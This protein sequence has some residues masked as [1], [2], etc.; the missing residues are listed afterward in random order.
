MKN[1]IKVAFLSSIIA[2]AMVYVILEWRPL[3]SDM[4]RPP[5]VSW[6]SSPVGLTVP[7]AP[8]KLTEDERNNIDIYQKYSPGVVNIT[9][10]TV[11]YN[12]FLQPFPQQGMGSG[13]VI[14]NQGHIVTNF[15]VVRDAD[16]LQV[17]LADKSKHNA[18]VVG[19]DPN[20]DLAVIQ[21][22][23]PRGGLTPIP[24]G[25]SKGLLV[26]QKVLAI[27]NPFGLDRTMTTGI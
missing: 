20:N 26:G 13:A 9:T 15:H 17:T 8:D 24:L 10:I 18:R 11:A 14:D 7:A 4:S 23:V 16:Q 21:I 2:A 1:L 5:D 3:R 12:V 22:D 27:G 19:T 6:A 25:T